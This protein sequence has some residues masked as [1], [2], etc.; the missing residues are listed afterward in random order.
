MSKQQFPKEVFVT[1][2][3]EGDGEDY[4]NA[5]KTVDDFSWDDEP[6]RRI[7]IYRLEKVITAERWISTSGKK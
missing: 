1:I 2:E 6:K 4:L 5:Q 7:A 3:N